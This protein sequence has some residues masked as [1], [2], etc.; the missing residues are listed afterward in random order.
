[1]DTPEAEVRV[2]RGG[3]PSP[4]YLLGGE[5]YAVDIV[6]PHTLGYGEEHYLGY[7]TLFQYSVPPPA[8]F[9]RAT[10]QRVEHLDMRV[11]LH[12]LQRPARL[13]W[14]RGRAHPGGEGI[15]RG[16]MPPEED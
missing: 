15:E 10:H 13:R 3:K 4:M 8:E 14:A 9:R 11:E 16:A 5:H 2:M 7:W 6:F 1:M 12:P